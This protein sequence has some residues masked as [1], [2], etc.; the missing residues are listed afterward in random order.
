MTYVSQGKLAPSLS[1]NTVFGADFAEN[2]IASLDNEFP[3]D[4]TELKDLYDYHSD[5]DLEDDVEIIEHPTT[6][7]QDAGLSSAS[8]AVRDGKQVCHMSRILY[9]VYL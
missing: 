5:S 6:E 3:A 8:Q 7:E 4:K 2:R 1:A 9:L